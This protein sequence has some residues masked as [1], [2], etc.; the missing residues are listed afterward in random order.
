MPIGPQGQWRPS[1][2][3]ENAVMVAKI[4]TGEITETLESPKES[5][6]A[7]F[8][9]LILTPEHEDVALLLPDESWDRDLRIP[10]SDE[11]AQGADSVTEK[12][13]S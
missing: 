7:L 5:V 3:I 1:D 13:A 11:S 9:G 12:L 2:P 4:A 6:L 10:E 8:D